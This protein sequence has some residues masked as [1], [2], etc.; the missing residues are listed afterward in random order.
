[1]AFVQ[2][3]NT[4]CGHFSVKWEIND[5]DN[6]REKRL[7]SARF[8]CP[9]SKHVFRLFLWPIS[10]REED[11]D[12]LSLFLGYEVKY[13]S[14]PKVSAKYTVTLYDRNNIK[15]VTQNVGFHT[16]S[17]ET[18][19]NYGMYRFMR[20]S[21]LKF[22]NDCNGSKSKITIITE[23]EE[24]EDL[25]TDVIDNK[26]QQFKT[27]C[28]LSSLWKRKTLTDVD[29]NVNGV[30]ISAHKAILSSASE[31]FA[32]MFE[33][34][35]EQICFEIQDFNETVVRKAIEFIYCSKLDDFQELCCDLLLFAHKFKIK[36]LHSFIEN[37]LLQS[38]TINNAIDYISI[39]DKTEANSLKTT[40]I[41]L[42][43]KNSKTIAAQEKFQLLESNVAK[44]LFTALI[45]IK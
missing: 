27:I 30:I 10:E 22:I 39:A 33:S 19:L 44:E 43:C 20:R 15:H 35:P 2:L 13:S 11:K 21:D 31:E 5:I 17:V 45:K 24:A 12:F 14:E 16:F 42:I 28:D 9:S 29:I 23:I 40:C 6:V 37:E 7:E 18:F 41:Q 25:I 8:C 26:A 3:N 38:L 1:M 36:G 34:N 32:T 4:K